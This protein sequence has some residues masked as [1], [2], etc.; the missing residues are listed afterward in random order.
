MKIYWNWKDEMEDVDDD[1]SD[2]TYEEGFCHEIKQ[3]LCVWCCSMKHHEVQGD[4]KKTH[5]RQGFKTTC[6]CNTCNVPH[7]AKPRY[8]GK[9]CFYLFHTSHVLKEPCSAGQTALHCVQAHSNQV[10]PPI[11]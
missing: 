7:C 3:I 9:S 4:M 1:D 2:D 10:D 5:S 8:D 6:K 11:R